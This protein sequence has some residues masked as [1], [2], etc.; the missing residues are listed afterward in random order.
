MDVMKRIVIMNHQKQGAKRG[1]LVDI[2]F[3]QLCQCALSRWNNIKS[4]VLFIKEYFYCY[5]VVKK[6]KECIIIGLYHVKEA[7]RWVFI[8]V[9][10]KVTEFGW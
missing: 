8:I 9:L 5:F 2:A 6:R 3:R 7:T 1:E 4:I 10:M